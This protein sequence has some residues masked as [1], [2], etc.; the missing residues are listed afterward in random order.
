MLKRGA[1]FR[2]K[3]GLS[4]LIATVLLIAFAVSMGAMIMNWSTSIGEAEGPPDCSGINLILNPAI[5]YTGNA[6]RL[7]LKNDGVLVSDL[8]LKVVDDAQENEINLK[9]SRL[10]RGESLNVDLPYLQAGNTYVAVTPSVLVK[11][12]SVPCDGPAIEVNSLQKC[13]G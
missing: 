2:S 10:R 13:S 12:E 11:D 5:C 8:S 3:R 7:G 4:P 6:I 1:F 9:N